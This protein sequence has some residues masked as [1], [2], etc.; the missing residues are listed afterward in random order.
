MKQI[1]KFA[2]SFDN[3][4]FSWEYDSVEEALA[5]AKQEVKS[6]Q[7]DAEVVY[8]GRIYEFEPCVDVDSIIERLQ[9]D[10]E[11]EAGECTGD[12]LEGVEVPDR[13]KLQ[14]M[15]T[16]TFNKWAKETGNEPTF[17]I[18]REIQKYSLEDSNETD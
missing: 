16:E 17:Y 12:Y 3:E 6:G 8:I 11:Y 9:Y 5:D 18:V 13:Q 1:D 15:L 14:E 7:E 2:Y 10:A 4:S